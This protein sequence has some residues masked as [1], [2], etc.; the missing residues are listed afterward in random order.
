MTMMISSLKSLLSIVL[1]ACSIA[2]APALDAG[3]ADEIIVPSPPLLSNPFADEMISVER[4]QVSV[5]LA[6]WLVYRMDF[7]NQTN[8]EEWVPD[9]YTLQMYKDTGSTEALILTKEGS[10]YVVF[11]GTDDTEDGDWLTNLNGI[12]V[13]L[14]PPNQT[15]KATAVVENF[16]FKTARRKNRTLSMAVHKGFNQVFSDNLYEDIVE[17]VD[18]LLQDEE[19]YNNTIYFVGHSLGGANAQVMGSY[20]AHFHPRIQTY[21][22][23]FGSPRQGNFVYKLFG[24]SMPNLNVWRLVYC[25]DVVARMPSVRYYHTGHLLWNHCARDGNANKVQAFYRQAGDLFR[26]LSHV[27]LL[28]WVVRPSDGTAIIADHFSPL[29]LGWIDIAK[30]SLGAS[31]WT[32][33]FESSL[34]TQRSLSSEDRKSS[35]EINHMPEMGPLMEHDQDISDKLKKGLRGFGANNR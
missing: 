33:T 25:R 19:T 12:K 35:D 2:A 15:L 14:G 30:E 17:V 22:T 8:V 18:D 32:N 13:P 24:E 31:N 11:R 28:E 7:N 1:L 23:T 34:S 20:Y 27:P 16:D 21:V 5:F 3:V 6:C 29:Y 4:A 9:D 10:I 26:D